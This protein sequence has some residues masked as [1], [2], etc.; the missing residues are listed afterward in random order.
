VVAERHQWRRG[1]DGLDER[2]KLGSLEVYDAATGALVNTIALGTTPG[3]AA[4][5]LGFSPGGRFLYHG[6]HQ[7]ILVVDLTGQAAPVELAVGPEFDPYWTVSLLAVRS[8]P[9]S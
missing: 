6:S 3:F 5:V 4:R 9:G 1:P 7:A 8:R 2:Y